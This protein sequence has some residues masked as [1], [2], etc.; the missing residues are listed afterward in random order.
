MPIRAERAGTTQPSEWVGSSPAYLR[1]G[2]V[3][4][5]SLSD[6]LPPDGASI[7]SLAV[8]ISVIWQR[9]GS[10]G[11]RAGSTGWGEIAPKGSLHYVSTESCCA[12]AGGA[13]EVSVEVVRKRSAGARGQIG[14]GARRGPALRLE[15]DH[16][17]VDTREE[18]VGARIPAPPG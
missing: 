5:S 14:T 16:T 8:L 9:V 2:T 4:G 3:S 1:D 12:T 6:T 13:G 15:I 17:E 18:R 7:A 11:R 10:P